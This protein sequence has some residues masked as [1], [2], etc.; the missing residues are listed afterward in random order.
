[1]V[2]PF[3]FSDFAVFPTPPCVSISRPFKLLWAFPEKKRRPPNGCLRP[4]SI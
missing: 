1:V 2:F 4:Y 3:L